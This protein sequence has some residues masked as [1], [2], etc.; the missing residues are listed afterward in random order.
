MNIC[1]HVCELKP[2][3]ALSLIFPYSLKAA[4]NEEDGKKVPALQDGTYIWWMFSSKGKFTLEDKNTTLV[5]PKNGLYLLNLKMY[6]NVDSDHQCKQM[7]FLKTI[8]QQ[9]HS[10]YPRWREV[11][12]GTDT[13][14]CV[15]DWQQSV[16][17]TQVI[18]LIKGTMLRVIIDPNNDPFIIWDQSTYFTVTRL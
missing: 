12:T 6:Y 18:R 9:Y 10:S 14:Q 11:I 7:L 17:L 5:V 16:T 15:Q 8:I 3:W 2:I 13:M 4:R 1:L